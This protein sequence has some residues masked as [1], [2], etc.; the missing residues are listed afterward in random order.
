VFVLDEVRDSSQTMREDVLKQSSAKSPNPMSVIPCQYATERTVKVIR[1]K[2]LYVN[3]LTDR[4]FGYALP[5]FEP[6]GIEEAI[7]TSADETATCDGERQHVPG[8]S[9]AQ[10]ERLLHIH[11]SARVDCPFHERSVGRGRCANVHDMG[12]SLAQHFVDIAV[13][14]RHVE[15]KSRLPCEIRI[16]VA[17]G[18]NCSQAAG[19]C[20]D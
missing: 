4:T 6:C 10:C 14:P 2:D 19:P 16:G 7:V 3:E 17:D 1:L 8:F 15:P 13:P 9:D 12:L 5:A 18:S 20:R 11:V